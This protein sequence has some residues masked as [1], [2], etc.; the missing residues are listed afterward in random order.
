[1][2]QRFSLSIGM[3]QLMPSHVPVILFPFEEQ[4]DAYSL[5]I[6]LSHKSEITIKV[7]HQEL[8]A[9]LAGSNFFAVVWFLAGADCVLR[10]CLLGWGG[11]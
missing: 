5:I 6:E 11:G 7:T 9:F 8:G 4:W 10:V 2:C 1:M 3:I